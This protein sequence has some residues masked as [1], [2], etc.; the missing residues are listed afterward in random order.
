MQNEVVILAEKLLV[1]ALF[2]EKFGHTTFSESLV[3]MS[4]LVRCEF[5][6]G[7]REYSVSGNPTIVS[8]YCFRTSHQKIND[9]T[10]TIS[11]AN[12]LKKNLWIQG[13]LNDLS[14]LADRGTLASASNNL[15]TIP[16]IENTSIAHRLSVPSRMIAR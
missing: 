15:K 2:A 9:S 13:T 4:C 12:F 3:E 8:S 6:A 1:V 7:D 16:R 10:K 5:F 11:G 14:T